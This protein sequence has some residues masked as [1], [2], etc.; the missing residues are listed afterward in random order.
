MRL[1]A[2]ENFHGDVLRGLLRLEPKLDI[3]RVQDMDLYQT[4]DPVVLEWAAKENRILLTHD[5]QTMTKHAY[6]RIRADLPMPGVIEVRDD[7]PIGQAIEE[8]LITLLASKPDELA[9]R[10]IHIP[11]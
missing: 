2:D 10:I 1:L 8:I 11:L 3:L 9:N 6:D 5:V 7:L 4:A